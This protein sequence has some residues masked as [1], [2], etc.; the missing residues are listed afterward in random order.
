MKEKYEEYDSCVTEIKAKKGKD[1]NF[2][3]KGHG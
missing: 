3:E 2:M 1:M